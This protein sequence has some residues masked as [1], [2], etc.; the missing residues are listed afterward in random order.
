M[1][2]LHRRSTPID[3]IIITAM[4]FMLLTTVC[5][6]KRCHG[7]Q[8]FRPLHHRQHHHYGGIV[9][10]VTS[11]SLR[12]GISTPYLP[13][14]HHRGGRRISKYSHKSSLIN[15]YSQTNNNNS[16]P[17]HDPNNVIDDDAATTTTTTTRPIETAAISSFLKQHLAQLEYDGKLLSEEVSSINDSLQNLLVLNQD[18]DEITSFH[19]HNNN[20]TVSN[21][22]HVIQT[23]IELFIAQRES[24]WRMKIRPIENVGGYVRTIVRNELSKSTSSSSGQYFVDA[25]EQPPGHRVG[26]DGGDGHQ[27]VV[28]DTIQ[29][30]QQWEQP[31]QVQQQQEHHQP[32]NSSKHDNPSIHTLLQPFIQRSQINQHELNESCLQTLNQTST[33]MV[34]YALEAYVR[35]KQRRLV[36][37]MVPI[38][39]PSSYVLKILG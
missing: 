23:S 22:T 28:V 26:D 6:P 12:Y 13:H 4:L 9:R 11:S 7:L 38:L 19:Y 31:Q 21:V 25:M 5:R 27:F 17:H 2:S 33:D 39:D 20:R 16:S 8:I 35:Q 18:D 34:Q 29:Q 15:L 36:K 14:S 37:G 1:P 10:S 3:S 24:R 32:K 30:P